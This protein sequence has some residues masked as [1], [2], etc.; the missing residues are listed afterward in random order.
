MMLFA[1]GG[2]DATG[3][4]LII[5]AV[6]A[7]IVMVIKEKRNDADRKEVKFKLAETTQQQAKEAA[8][9]AKD[10]AAASVERKEVKQKLSDTV[11]A[12]ETGL[13]QV[14]NAVWETAK[15]HDSKL[16]KVL[17]DD[18]CGIIASLKKIADWIPLHEKL[19]E[20]RNARMG[21]RVERI[22]LKTDQIKTKVDRIVD[23]IEH[24]VEKKL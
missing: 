10:R 20:D 1:D 8:V 16:D 4:V 9:A 19:D 5:G 24:L 6:F 21:E 11:H 2:I 23:S 22:E 17:G 14:Q 18:E 7:G 12:Q 13:S 15:S 3:W